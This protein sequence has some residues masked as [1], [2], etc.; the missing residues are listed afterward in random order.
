MHKIPW[1]YIKVCTN[2]LPYSIASNGLQDDPWPHICRSHMSDRL[3][4]ASLYHSSTEMN[5]SMWIQWPF[6]PK[7]LSQNSPKKWLHNRIC[8]PSNWSKQIQET[9]TAYSSGTQYTRQSLNEKQHTWLNRQT[10]IVCE[11]MYVIF[12]LNF[13]AY[14]VCRR[15]KPC[16]FLGFVWTDC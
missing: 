2:S 14:I 13:A 5:Q 10:V 1:K 6:S 12:H 16:E 8:C 9:H 4:Q 7:N 15:Y 3:P 11:A